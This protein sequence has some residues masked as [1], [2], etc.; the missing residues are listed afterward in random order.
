MKT[1][2]KL[3]TKAVAERMTGREYQNE[4]TLDEEKELAFHGLVVVFGYSDDNVELRGAITEEIGCYERGTIPILDGDVFMPPCGDD[5]E[6][7]DCPLLKDAYRRSEKI[8]AKCTNDGWKFDADFP[9]ETFTIMED[10]ESFGEGI[11]FDMEDLK[12]ENA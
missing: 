6:K 7:Y 5:C 4:I 9:H 12:H 10:G 3:T 1:P 11:V 2:E 8:I